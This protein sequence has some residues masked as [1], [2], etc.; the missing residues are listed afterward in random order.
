MT[1]ALCEPV[2]VPI[3]N[4]VLGNVV[5][6]GRKSTADRTNTIAALALILFCPLLLF[7]NWNTLEK[8]DA[9]FQKAMIAAH[10]YPVEFARSLTPSI[11]WNEAMG[12]AAWLY[13]Q[14]TL[15]SYLPGKQ[16]TGQLTP[17]GHALKYITNGLLSWTI[18]HA[19]FVAL[20]WY[21]WIDPAIIAKHWEGLLVAGNTYGFVLAILVQLKGYY[22]P[23]FLEDCK[24]SGSLLFDFWGGVEL[25]P[26]I[27]DLDLKFFH[28]GRPG[29]IA[30]SL[31]NLSWACYQY[32]SLG[33]VSQ[34]MIV[35]NLLQAIYIL[36]FFCNEA[37]YTHTVDISHDHFGFMLAWGDTAFLPAFYTL[38]AQ[39][40]ARQSGLK[41]PLYTWTLLFVG[42]AAYVVFRAANAQRHR[43]RR[44][45]IEGVKAPTVWG[46]PAELIHCDYVTSDGKRHQTIL[47]ASGW[48]GT[49][50]HV[51]YA[52]DLV[53]A[54][55]MC[56]VCG[57]DHIL[58]WFYFLYMAIL[59]YHRS[60]R[61]DRR[62]RK[63]YGE[64]WAEYC[65]RVPY[66]I[67]PGIY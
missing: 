6:W 35:L 50:R 58:P 42:V 24:L 51:N 60:I 10:D 12:Y 18:T 47:L 43:V 59:L 19:T 39:Y 38:Q 40:L 52:A 8:Y 57:F 56:A 20:A 48:W 67:V 15:Y 55:C 46:R 16:C 32:Q 26:R 25:N 34:P 9:S 23:T 65:A 7:A 27:G 61:D 62:C 22:S 31:I 36:D 28:N 21:S 37:W 11:T 3:V 1:T 2:A 66:R 29:I 53:Q 4:D 44:Q 5:A 64:K 45:Y 13:W 30:W 14:Q 33:Y 54:W 41:S 49:A 17:G 63:K